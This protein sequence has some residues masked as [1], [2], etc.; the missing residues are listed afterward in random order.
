MSSI[1]MPDAQIAEVGSGDWA[2]FSVK[3]AREMKIRLKMA[4]A[5][6]NMKQQEILTEALE[7]WMQQ[8]GLQKK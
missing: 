8:E 2:V 5:I 7:L 3:L 6:K 1:E 4:S